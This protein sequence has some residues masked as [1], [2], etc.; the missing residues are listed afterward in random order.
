MELYSFRPGKYIFVL[1]VKMTSIDKFVPNLQKMY[2][3]S[4][5]TVNVLKVVKTL[6]TYNV[7]RQ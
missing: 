1:H 4:T 6:L 5:V 3:Y 2:K 7:L